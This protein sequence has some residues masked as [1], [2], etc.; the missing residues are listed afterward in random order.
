M[1][2]WFWKCRLFFFAANYFI[3]WGGPRLVLPLNCPERSKWQFRGQKSWGPIKIPR[4]KDIKYF[5][6]KQKISQIFNISSTLV[7]W[8]PIA[9]GCHQKPLMSLYEIERKEW[10]YGYGLAQTLSF[11]RWN[12]FIFHRFFWKCGI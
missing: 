1:Y 2:R 8:C 3:F 6:Q 7:I 12:F 11:D 4:E 5:A 9:S 10:S